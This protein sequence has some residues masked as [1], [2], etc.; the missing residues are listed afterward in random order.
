[1]ITNWF[2][3]TQRSTTL[4][5]TEAEYCAL[6]TGAQ[7]VL[8]QTMLLE[9]ITGERKPAIL[10]EDNTGAIF[11]VKNQQVGP[12]TKHIDVRHHFI[13]ELH[14]DGSLVVKYTESEDNEADMMTKNVVLLLLSKHRENVR[15]GSMFCYQK[16]D[17]IIAEDWREDVK[18]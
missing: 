5:S 14:E 18:V 15:N 7:E 16:W 4:S 2:S 10:L 6:A 12:R 3:Q 17:E 1:M 8:F 9:E 13:R 11:L